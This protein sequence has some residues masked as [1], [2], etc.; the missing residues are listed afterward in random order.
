MEITSVC[1]QWRLLKGNLL[2]MELYF[3][4]SLAVIADHVDIPQVNFK[5]LIWIGLP[6]KQKILGV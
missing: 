2:C 5:Y 4:V 1:N 6:E 3:T